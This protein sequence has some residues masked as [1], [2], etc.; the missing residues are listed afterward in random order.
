MILHLADTLLFSGFQGAAQRVLRREQSQRPVRGR[1]RSS[2]GFDRA[3]PAFLPGT[4]LP[5]SIAGRYH[6]PP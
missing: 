3:I 5:L 6:A 1:P 4:G 2:T